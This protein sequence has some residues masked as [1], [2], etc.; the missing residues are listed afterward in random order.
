[1][2]NADEVDN[3]MVVVV[4]DFSEGVEV[5]ALLVNGRVFLHLNYLC[6]LIKSYT[7][8]VLNCSE[9]WIAL[10]DS[11]IGHEVDSTFL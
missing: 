5:V 9:S 6:I 10:L 4:H 8:L 1:M 7:V 3:L 11:P 2:K